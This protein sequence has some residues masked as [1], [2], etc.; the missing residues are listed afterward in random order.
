[1]G[2]LTFTVL[3]V[4]RL[5]AP[6]I[7]SGVEHYQKRIRPYASL[8]L[9]SVKAESGG[10]GWTAEEIARR[11]AT[12]LDRV[13]DDRSL[14]V[15]LDASGRRVSSREFASLLQE[16]MNRGTSRIG[17]VVG[18]PHGVAPSLRGR[19]GMTLS[20]SPMTLSHELALLVLVEQIYRALAVLNRLPY[21]K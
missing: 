2:G 1:M 8:R 19:A 12:R 5:K 18:G 17:F 21:P 3:H 11:E 10:K 13:M 9:T 7:R 14:W 16:W 6:F 20:L 4:G 15:A